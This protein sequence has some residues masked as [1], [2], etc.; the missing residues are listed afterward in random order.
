MFDG[1][2]DDSQAAAGLQRSP[3]RTRPR[4]R[5]A[6]LSEVELDP[7]GVSE[8]VMKR[9][10]ST[11]NGCYVRRGSTGFVDNR[12]ASKFFGTLIAHSYC[13]PIAAALFIARLPL[14]LPLPRTQGPAFVPGRRVAFRDLPCIPPEELKEG[15]LMLFRDKSPGSLLVS[16]HCPHSLPAHTASTHC[17]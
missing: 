2:T 13:M 7:E 8:R 14:L 16:P 12:K 10:P 9:C 5:S 17:S 1:T 15:D 6:S 4:L 11:G 3:I